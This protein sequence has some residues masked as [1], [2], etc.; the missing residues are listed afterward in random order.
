VIGGG[1]RAGHYASTNQAEVLE[2]RPA[3]KR[4]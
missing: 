1:R 3:R 4:G 2:L